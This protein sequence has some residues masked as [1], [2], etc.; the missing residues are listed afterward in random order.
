M[1]MGRLL[2]PASFLARLLLKNSDIIDMKSGRKVG[3]F[4][5][6]ALCT[7]DGQI[8]QEEVGLL[9]GLCFPLIMID[10]P[11]QWVSDS[12]GGRRR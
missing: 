4:W 3:L 8:H 6:A 5:V 12:G 7:P 1:T 11:V 2:Q 10:R 9:K